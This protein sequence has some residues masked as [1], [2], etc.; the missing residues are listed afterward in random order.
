[1]IKATIGGQR[2]NGALHTTG[3]QYSLQIPQKINRPGVDE[4]LRS[5]ARKGVSLTVQHEDFSELGA[6]ISWLRSGYLALVAM[7]GYEI[8]LDPAMEIVRKQMLECD[9]RR[10]VTFTVEAQED[11]PLTVRRVLRIV[12]P[13]WKTGLAVQFGR[14][15]VEFPPRGD[16]SFYDRL[17]AHCSETVVRNTTYEYLGWPT[18]PTFGLPLDGGHPGQSKK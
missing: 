18:E 13:Q 11:I 7:F 8:A 10:M 15:V 14:Y 6:K 3:G 1:M 12:E 2:L 9:E 4:F 16:M 17:A 5:T